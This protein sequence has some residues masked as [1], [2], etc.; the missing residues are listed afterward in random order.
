MIIKSDNF[1]KSL[2]GSPTKADNYI[3]TMA[4]LEEHEDKY[5]L[6]T[7]HMGDDVLGIKCNHWACK[8]L[9]LEANMTNMRN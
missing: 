4:A 7:E 6:Q 5:V 8:Q 1:F 3:K 2:K 9:S